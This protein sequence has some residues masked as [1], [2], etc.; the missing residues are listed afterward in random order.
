MYI[1]KFSVS[2]EDAYAYHLI[3]PIKCRCGAIDEYINRAKK[4]CHRIKQELFSLT[5]LLH[6]QQ[7]IANKTNEITSE[8][9][10]KFSP[11]SFM[12][13]IAADMMFSGKVFLIMLGAAV[14]VEIFLFVVT[15]LMFFFGLAFQS[16]NI[17]ANGNELF[18]GI[19]IFKK[20][21]GDFL[22]K[23]GF[24]SAAA[25]PLSEYGTNPSEGLIFDYIPA[26]VAG[27]VI[28][29][30]YVFLAVLVVRAAISVSKLTF[31]ASKVMNQKIKINQKRE[32]YKKQLD[33]L[34]IIYQNLAD[35]IGEAAVLPDDYK[36]IRA[37][38]SILGYFVNN[39]ADSIREAMALF[40]DE[41]F[42]SKLLEYTKGLY[43]E[44]KQTRRYTKAMYMMTSD[45]N[46][47]VDIK[48]PKEESSENDGDAAKNILNDAFSRIK[49]TSP[50]KS[51]RLNSPK[52]GETGENR[53]LEAP[54]K[55][56]PERAAPGGAPDEPDAAANANPA[57]EYPEGNSGAAGD[58]GSG[59]AENIGN[60]D[61]GA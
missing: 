24:E 58:A 61:A 10:K 27:L 18:Y 8:L 13:S 28:V 48:E 1:E 49:N 7:N 32:E 42:K 15:A 46:I 60:G 45:E 30:F 5:D 50:K 59:N 36:N 41:D 39:R 53:T 52:P 56:K 21:G 9:N 20:Q 55:P 16:E 2:D 19:N 40:H 44:A 23:L 11:P 47:K 14:G 3:A 4:S 35:Q 37:T 22:S 17:A 51:P 29:V 31:F 12:Q 34:G 25:R 54:R 57:F 38:D 33:D 43:T 6:K 26:A